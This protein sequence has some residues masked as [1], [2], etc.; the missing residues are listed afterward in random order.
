MKF[1]LIL[2]LAIA[3]YVNI[4]SARN[5]PDPGIDTS[6]AIEENG[7]SFKTNKYFISKF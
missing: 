2:V 3:Q 7:F 4:A 6:D 1:I 5:L